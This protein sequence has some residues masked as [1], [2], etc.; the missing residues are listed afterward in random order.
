MLSVS[1]HVHYVHEPFAPMYER[2][3]ALALP[4][5]RYRDE[6]PERPSVLTRTSIGS[7]RSGH[8]GYAAPV[9]RVAC[10]TLCERRRKQRKL[11]WLGAAVPV[12]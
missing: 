11:A 8:H 6:A 1:S 12:H 7:S 5:E 10:V 4:P 3:R 9:T 2:A